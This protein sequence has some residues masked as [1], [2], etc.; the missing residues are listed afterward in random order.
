MSWLCCIGARENCPE[1][2]K[3]NVEK[4]KRNMISDTFDVEKVTS[5]KLVFSKGDTSVKNQDR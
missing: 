4:R 1:D 3:G 5:D 2:S